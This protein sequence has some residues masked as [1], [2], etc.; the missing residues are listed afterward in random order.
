MLGDASAVSEVI[1]EDRADD[2]G[3]RQGNTSA[4]IC[5][6]GKAASRRTPCR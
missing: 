1:I 6:R 3:V 4:Q 2:P 5:P